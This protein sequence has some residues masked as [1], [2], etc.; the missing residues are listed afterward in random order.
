[1]A[2]YFTMPYTYLIQPGLADDLWTIR[3]VGA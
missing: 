2:G 3:I 1:M